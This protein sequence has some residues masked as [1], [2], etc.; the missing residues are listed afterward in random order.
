MALGDQGWFM[1][2]GCKPPS[3]QWRQSAALLCVFLCSG[4]QALNRMDYLDQFFDPKAYAARHTVPTPR[5]GQAVQP[6]NSPEQGR[7]T[8]TPQQPPMPNRP[9]LQVPAEEAAPQAPA[10]SEREQDQWVR[11][12]LRQNPWLA[13]NWAQL[14]PAQQLRI[15]RQ[16]SD[17]EAKEPAA[18]WDTM[19][20][21]DRAYLAFGSSPSSTAARAA[22]TQDAALTPYR[23]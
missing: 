9:S 1:R 15:E 23:R 5:D 12:N 11:G 13:L 19:G 2:S 7:G 18:A 6:A 17:S 20:L 21:N 16:L 4:C 22:P 10:S 14:T 3:R 8:P